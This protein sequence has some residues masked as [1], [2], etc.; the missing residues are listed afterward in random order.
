ME[1]VM[2]KKNVILLAT[3]I[4]LGTMA[5]DEPHVLNTP[6]P[7]VHVYVIKFDKPEY[8][9]HIMVYADG[10]GEET[11]RLCN[12]RLALPDSVIHLCGKSPYIELPNNYLLVD[13]KWGRIY[14]QNEEA[15]IRSKWSELK[16]ADTLW[17]RSEIYVKYPVSEAYCISREVIK[18]YN[19]GFLQY[20]DTDSTFIRLGWNVSDQNWATYSEGLKASTLEYLALCDSV[21]AEFVEIITRMIQDGN[22]PNESRIELKRK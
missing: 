15:I 18:D 22:L 3:S 19:N 17:P 13:W 7:G 16:A 20:Y 5:C 14:Y 2:K 8:K 21:Q 6:D 4:L 11:T 9:E 1:V 12:E 10:F